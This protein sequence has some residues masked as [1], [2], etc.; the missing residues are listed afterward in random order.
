MEGKEEGGKE[1]IE[2]KRETETNTENIKTK[3]HEKKEIYKLRV[4]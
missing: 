3:M 2:R 1:E 4:R